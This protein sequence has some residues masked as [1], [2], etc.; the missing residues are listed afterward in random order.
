MGKR[1]DGGYKSKFRNKEQFIHFLQKYI[2]EEWTKEIRPENIRLADQEFVLANFGKRY[3]DVVWEVKLAGRDIY[4]FIIVE[5]QTRTDFTM[6]LRTLTYSTGVFLNIYENTDQKE[7]TSKGF[8]MPAVVAIV[9][10]NGEGRWTAPTRFRDYQEGYELFGDHGIDFE[11]Y[12]VDLS[13]LPQNYIMSTN[14]LI[15]NIFAVDQVRE[16]EEMLEVLETVGKRVEKL[17]KK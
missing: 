8:R 13:Q 15:D 14:K 11:Y 16:R 7:R 6:P 12:L 3:L 10:H 1:N 5:Q 9:F 2:G 17:D 4:V